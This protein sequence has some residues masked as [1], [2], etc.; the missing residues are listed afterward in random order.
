[1][2]FAHT[3]FLLLVS[4]CPSLFSL[5]LWLSPPLIFY[6]SLFL[7]LFPFL[8]PVS[9][10]PSFSPFLCLLPFSS[11]CSTSLSSVS[12]SHPSL[13]SLLLDGSWPPPT[14][15]PVPA[16]VSWAWRGGGAGGD[17]AVG[18]RG[19]GGSPHPPPPG[20]QKGGS[21]RSAWRGCR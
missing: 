3:W 1:M 9:L 8:P 2:A 20:T 11:L 17:Q 16:P 10:S 18:R 19:G 13:R 4:V 5:G 12:P 7:P 6:F 14:P 15:A 21:L